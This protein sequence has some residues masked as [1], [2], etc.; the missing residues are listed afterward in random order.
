MGNTPVIHGRNWHR[1]TVAIGRQISQCIA[2]REN[3]SPVDSLEQLFPF[4]RKRFNG[5]LPLAAEEQLRWAIN[6]M[7]DTFT[8][9]LQKDILPLDL[10]IC[11]TGMITC[12]ELLRKT[13]PNGEKSFYRKE[14]ED[15]IEREIVFLQ[16]NRSGSLLFRGRDYF[17]SCVREKVPDLLPAARPSN[18]WA[19][20]MEGIEIKSELLSQL[21]TRLQANQNRS[22][23]KMMF[24]GYF[25]NAFD[26]VQNI[27]SAQATF[28]RLCWVHFSSPRNAIEYLLQG[29]EIAGAMR[30]HPEQSFWAIVRQTKQLTLKQWESC[31]ADDWGGDGWYVTKKPH[32]SVTE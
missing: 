1:A 19:L 16:N 11:E 18:F 28:F 26:K 5:R 27:R 25:C 23:L 14:I 6:E 10:F 31:M 32:I 9:L 15:N 7:P 8:R 3:H 30:A 20:R 2:R 4:Y 12:V 24:P 13:A 22:S 21:E 29:G 17:L